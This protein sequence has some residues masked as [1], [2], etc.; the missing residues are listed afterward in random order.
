M[1]HRPIDKRAYLKRFGSVAV[2]VKGKPDGESKDPDVDGFAV[3]DW[4]GVQL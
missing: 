2:S 3:G 4:V 1:R